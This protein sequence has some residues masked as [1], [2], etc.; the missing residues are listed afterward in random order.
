MDQNVF[1][2]QD[3]AKI[4]ES[5]ADRAIHNLLMKL[6]IDATK[7]E[8]IKRFRENLNFLDDQRRGSEELKETLKKGSFYVVGVFLMGMLYVGWDAL[9]VGGKAMRI[10]IFGS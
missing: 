6:D 2:E 5:A 10:F 7:P 4:A 1:T 8:Q 3:V 9:K